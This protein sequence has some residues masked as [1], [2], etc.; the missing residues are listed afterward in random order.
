MGR[1]ITG[2]L[3]DH[4]RK[5]RTRA[6]LATGLALVLIFVLAEVPDPLFSENYATTLWSKDGQL[7]SAA[8]A[9]DEQ[10]RFAP[11][12]SIPE[13]FKTAITLFEDEYFDYHLGVNPVSI[14]RAI[15]QNYRAGKTISGGSTLTMQTIRMAYGNQPRTYWQKLKEVIA[16]IKLELLY[17]KGEILKAYADHAPFGGNFVGLSAASYRYFGRAP[18][19]LSWSEV[20]TLAVLPNNPASIF[21]GSN[22][23]VLRQKRNFLLEKLHRRGYIDDDELLLAKRE[24]LPQ[25][26]KAL[27]SMAYHLLYRSIDEGAVGANIKTTLD[28]RLQQRATRIINQHS[29]RLSANEI[30]NAAAIILDIG[31]GNTLAYVGNSDNVED[32]GQHVDVITAQRSPGSLL[33]PILYAA[34]IDAELILPE[35]LLPD[36][37]LFHKG[38]APK[39][40]NK[41]F[42]GAIPANQ[43]L[44][45]SLNVPFV[46]LLIE[47]GHEKFHEKLKSIGFDSFKNSADHYGL[48]MI[49]GGAETSLWEVTAVYA[50]LARVLQNYTERPYSSGYS[51]TDFRPNIYIESQQ[52]RGENPFSG[53]GPLRVEALNFAFEAMTKLQRPEE[54]TGWEYFGTSKKISW[55]TGTSYGFRDGWAIGLNSQ[56]LVG[57]WVGNADGEGRPGLTGIKTAA[58]IMFDLFD[59][60]PQSSELGGV[61]GAPERVCQQSGMRLGK[62]CNDF[63]KVNLPEFLLAT[64]SCTFHQPLNLNSEG[65]HQVNSSCYSVSE[66]RNEN[67][68][69]LPAVQAWYYHQHHPN[70]KSTPSFLSSCV[71]NESK[72]FFQLIYPRKFSKVIIPKEQDGLQGEVVFEAA[73]HNVDTQVFWHLD[74][75]YLGVT[76]GSHKMGIQ[77]TSGAHQVTLVDESGRV[78]SQR[79]VVE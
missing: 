37:P 8:I 19:S 25:K 66:I 15:G 73:H 39:N 79:F 33:K 14:V 76:E 47:Y 31:T 17:S 1:S 7:L 10:W 26:A 64:S 42:Q 72:H 68:F 56:H 41:T 9:K 69:I 67:W 53:D 78:I 75:Q 32:H 49:L 38:F 65:T 45:S 77:T 36:V 59:L 24:R 30:Q 4:L 74:N 70:F 62:Y 3:K 27:P 50:S 5:K 18:H 44:T 13:K 12:D 29:K 60:I 35:Q 22:S 34:A 55:K 61:F 54:E 46:H 6:I 51:L 52:K 57:V 58:P 23:S 28:Q 2:R 40:F 11:S 20:A 16:A 48:S 21:P 71:N 63:R 43:A